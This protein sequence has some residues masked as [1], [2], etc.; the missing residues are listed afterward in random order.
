MNNLVNIYI[1]YGED[2]YFK[3]ERAYIYDVVYDK[4]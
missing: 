4:L 1:E 3:R 2:M